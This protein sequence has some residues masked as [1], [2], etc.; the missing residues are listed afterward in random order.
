MRCPKCG[1]QIPDG[2]KTCVLCGWDMVQGDTTEVPIE[3]KLSM[4]AVAS[5]VLGV[6]SPLTL[7]T[8]TM[9]AIIL[10]ICAITRIR[11]SNGRLKGEK[12][13]MAGTII[14]IFAIPSVIG[15]CVALWR[16]D[17]PPIP[18]D[19]TIGDLRCADPE[20]APSYELLMSLADEQDAEPNVAPAIGLSASDIV[21]LEEISDTLKAS[22]YSN[23]IISQTLT[24]ESEGIKQAWQNAKKGR[25]VIRSL[26]KFPEI[27]DLTEQSYEADLGFLENLQ[28]LA[29]ICRL[30]L[31]LQS[32]LGNDKDAITEL[33][34]LDS[35]FRKLSVNARTMITKLVC[36]G[37]FRYN[38]ISANF[39]IN[40]S[41]ASFESLEFL[42]GQFPHLTDEQV[43]LRNAFI[44]EYLMFK[45]VLDEGIYKGLATEA[46]KYNLR[47]RSLF[48]RN[49]SLRLYRHSCAK[50][51]AAGEELEASAGLGYSV[52]PGF[53]FFLP[54]VS[55]EEDVEGGLVP[56][57]P[58]HYSFYN[59]IGSMLIATMQPA[60][61]K[62]VALKTKVRTHEDLFQIVLNKRLGREVSLKARAY[63]DEYIIDVEKKIIFSPGPD[64]ESYTKDDIKL[65]INPDV[66]NPAQ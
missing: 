53:C 59:P 25:D 47:K 61:E 24:A 17:A 16:I 15:V 32:E 54:D 49:S 51:L 31:C 38:I 35:L 13:A 52:W 6:L 10:G 42:Q 22:D 29:L 33:L 1:T 55:F 30:H 3:P 57:F 48:K 46:Q 45:N 60:F 26:I 4:L 63:S 7:L 23:T 40:R 56:G 43:S 18:N 19:Y 62:I 39:I 36:Y 28:R 58:W 50:W 14:P 37:G 64:G 66:V 41:H 9:P 27:A 2:K 65:P 20:Y 34:E 5:L 44:C 21:M 12:I 11:R 8:T